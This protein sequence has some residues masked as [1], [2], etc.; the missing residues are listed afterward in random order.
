MAFTLLTQHAV[1]A[2]AYHHEEKKATQERHP[3]GDRLWA[4]N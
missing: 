4:V 3:E 2:D 1:E